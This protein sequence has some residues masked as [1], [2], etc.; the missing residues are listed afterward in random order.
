[1]NIVFLTTLN[2]YDINNWSGTTSHL[3]QALSKKHNVKVIGQ[4][5]LSLTAYYIKNNFSKKYPFGNYAPL[6]G[7]FHYFS[8]VDGV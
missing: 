7:R 1:M 4:N 5:T 3:L 2:P 8:L 6:F